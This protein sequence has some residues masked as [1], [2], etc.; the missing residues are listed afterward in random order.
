VHLGTDLQPFRRSDCLLQNDPDLSLCRT[1]VPGS[2]QAQCAINFLG[3]VA[4]R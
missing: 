1:A 4:N 2:A 3:E